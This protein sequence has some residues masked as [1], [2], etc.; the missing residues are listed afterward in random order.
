V[1]KGELPPSKVK[2]VAQ[3]FRDFLQEM[4][5]VKRSIE[6]FR[7]ET[8]SINFDYLS[9]SSEV[10]LSITVPRGLSRKLGSKIEIPAHAGYSIKEVLDLE[11]GG[12]IRHGF[13][14]DNNK[15]LIPVSILPSSEKYLIFLRGKV[16]KAFLDSFVRILAP[17]SA[18][19]DGERDK[20]WITATLR[21]IK[22]IEQIY[23]VF[24]VDNVTVGVD[25]GVQRIFS[26]AMP[27]KM[28]ARFDAHADFVAISK[29][30]AR[31]A[32]I[33]KAKAYRDS[34]RKMGGEPFDY[35]NL[36]VEL[37]SG[38]FFRDFIRIDTPRF[39]IGK[40]EGDPYFAT[41]PEK[42]LVEAQSRLTRDEPVAEGN[43]I[44]ERAKYMEAVESRVDETFKQRRKGKRRTKSEST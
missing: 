33:P 9:R 44:F 37:I 15:W 16:S 20:Y 35:I 42:V 25:I 36:V 11:T 38:D 1:G 3:E 14:K 23:D 10:R 17:S 2:R 43:L 12:S 19:R 5:D 13:V 24:D 22:R 27:K 18:D 21:D 6:P 30:R 31:E 41:L 29:S 39:S 7:P 28:K 4:Q 8:T 32:W 34:I 26:T 40:V